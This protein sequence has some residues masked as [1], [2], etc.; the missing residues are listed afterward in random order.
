[1]NEPKPWLTSPGG[2]AERLNALLE[3]TGLSGREFAA[4]LRW[5]TSKVSRIRRGIIA[6]KPDDV[7][8]W[9]RAAGGEDAIPDLLAVLA[10]ARVHRAD[11]FRD[12]MA[13]GQAEVQRDYTQLTAESAFIAYFEVA[14]IPGFLQ[15]REYMRH[16]FAEMVK[17]HGPR[18][19]VDEAI[20]ERMR[21]QQYLHD[22]AK[23][24]ELLICEPALHWRFMPAGVMRTQLAY[25]T[26]WLDVPNVRLGILPL[27]ASLPL[28]PQN[29]FE[30]YDDLVVVEDFAGE[31][32]REPDVYRR[33]LAEMWE[34]AAEHD[35]A[36]LLIEAAAARLLL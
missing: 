13:R 17:L 3:Q 22:L 21:R 18:D 20:A 19:D 1:M 33:V 4:R 8:A 34:V 6:P 11:Y 35:E 26:T 28:M 9:A 16:V 24:F 25:L 23:R 7:D 12:R 31:V 30:V 10:A 27:R 14:L 2:I 32:E 15:T 29:K 5:D 36:R